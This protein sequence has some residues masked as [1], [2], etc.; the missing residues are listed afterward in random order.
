MN[1]PENPAGTGEAAN[2][3]ATSNAAQ[4]AP[5]TVS[6]S[7]ITE[8]HAKSY[9]GFDPTIHATNE[10]GTPKMRAD[11]S[12]YAKK[13]GRKAGKGEALPDVAR[14]EN[15]PLVAPVEEKPRISAEQM[16]RQCANWF[17]GCGVMIFGKEWEPETKDEAV[18]LK[19]AFKDYFDAAGTP[20][21][22]PSLGLIAALGA[23]SLGRIQHE[24]TR[25]K[26][27]RAWFWLRA[28]VTGKL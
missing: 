22:P 20:D 3:T 26:I 16:S 27:G 4:S 9:E 24:N 23:Y 6:L 2:D 13:R 15:L 5:D 11:G 8:G 28:K 7:S 1:T 12:G 21:L 18:G 25:G 10:D 14:V 17:I 19:T